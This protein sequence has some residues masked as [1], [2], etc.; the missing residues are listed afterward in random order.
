[1]LT[2]IHA[3]Q[4]SRAG[5]ELKDNKEASIRD[6][7]LLDPEERGMLISSRLSKIKLVTSYD[8]AHKIFGGKIKNQMPRLT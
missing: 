6:L 5:F 3:H 4:T 1:M 8:L 7:S 2:E